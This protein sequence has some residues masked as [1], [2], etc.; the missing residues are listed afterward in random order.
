[1]L[2]DKN[3]ICWAVLVFFAFFF[4][5]LLRD[6]L[7]YHGGVFEAHSCQCSA[8]SSPQGKEENE[9][10]SEQQENRYENTFQAEQ[11]QYGTIRGGT[12]LYTTL[13]NVISTSDRG[14][15]PQRKTRTYLM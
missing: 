13:K 9:R 11:T 15:R 4:F 6:M 3:V 8:D 2:A 5:F 1:M 7:L 12:K 10:F 14:R